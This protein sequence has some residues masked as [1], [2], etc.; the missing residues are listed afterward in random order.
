MVLACRRQHAADARPHGAADAHA[1]KS[2]TEEVR[3]AT[4]RLYAPGMRANALRSP[5]VRSCE[6]RSARMCACALSAASLCARSLPSVPLPPAHV[7]AA[8]VWARIHGWLWPI[9]RRKGLFGL[10]IRNHWDAVSPARQYH[11]REE[12]TLSG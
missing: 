6:L 10:N 3:R 2:G 12:E 9:F 5:G 4:S 11:L 7:R 8:D 1:G